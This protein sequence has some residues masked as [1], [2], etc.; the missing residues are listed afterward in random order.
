MWLLNYRDTTAKTFLR[1]NSSYQHITQ[2]IC[3]INT[4]G[5]SAVKQMNS[6]LNV[7]WSIWM[8][9]IW[10][11]NWITPHSFKIFTSYPY[12]T[13]GELVHFQNRIVLTPVWIRPLCSYMYGKEI[14][15]ILWFYKWYNSYYSSVKQ[16]YS[17]YFKHNKQFCWMFINQSCPFILVV[18]VLRSQSN[19]LTNLAS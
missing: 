11:A 6:L 18:V 16:Y 4:I 12:L 7:L 9:D 5:V 3:Y 13:L 14:V 17:F 8:Q 1:R 10:I 2:N 19:F 15:Q